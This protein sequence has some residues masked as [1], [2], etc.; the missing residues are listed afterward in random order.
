MNPRSLRYQLDA[1]A[2]QIALL[3]GAEEDGSPS[4]LMRAMLRLHT[5]LET[6]RPE[7]LTTQAIWAL[8][9]RIAGLSDLLTAAY[10]R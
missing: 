6:A 5:D 7:D 2:D 1:L 8:R 9:G 10:L 4:D 3:P